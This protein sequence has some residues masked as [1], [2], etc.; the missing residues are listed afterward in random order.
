[1]FRLSDKK[2]R[3]ELKEALKKANAKFKAVGAEVH[4]NYFDEL[5]KL[6]HSNRRDSR[7]YYK[8]KSL[9]NDYNSIYLACISFLALSVYHEGAYEEELLPVN[10]LSESGKPNPN[11][12]LRRLLTSLLNDSLAIKFLLKEG[13]DVQARILLRSTLELTWQILILFYN[14][15]DFS[16]Y[17][18]AEFSDEIKKTYFSLFSR[19]KTYNK[20]KEIESALTNEFEHEMLNSLKKHRQENFD[21]Y[22]HIAHNSFNSVVFGSMNFIPNTDGLTDG[23]FGGVTEATEQTLKALNYNLWYF[24]MIFIAIMVAKYRKNLTNLEGEF[25]GEV[26]ILY[27]FIKLSQPFKP[28]TKN[29]V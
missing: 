23:I 8:K 7:K 2:I 28:P 21:F 13:F 6:F 5:A 18:K 20:L 19:D 10:W 15:D 4:L 16:R 9:Q 14:R 27:S 22:S 29:A 25:W 12:V 11:F 17:C 1:M 26:F 24:I 3:K